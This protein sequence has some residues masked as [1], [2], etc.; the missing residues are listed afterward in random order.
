[1]PCPAVGQRDARMPRGTA[2]TIAAEEEERLVRRE[3]AKVVRQHLQVVLANFRVGGIKI[4]GFQ[5]TADQALIRE[6]MIEASHVLLRQS[7]TLAQ[8]GPAVVSIHELAA[9]P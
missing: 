5:R 3:I 6:I 9:E 8:A 2:R 1:M 4:G 7:V